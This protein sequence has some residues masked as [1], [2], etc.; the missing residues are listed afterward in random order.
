MHPEQIKAEIR[1]RGT[2][3]AALAVQLRVS[4]VSV[5]NVIHQRSK[6]RRIAKA[7]SLLIRKPASELWPG[8]Y[9]DTKNK[10]QKRNASR[11]TK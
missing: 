10:V 11:R 7:I 2:T 8:V 5:S 4:Q 1:M 3:P 6:S 9:E